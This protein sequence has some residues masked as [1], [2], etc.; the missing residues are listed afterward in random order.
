MLEILGEGVGKVPERVGGAYSRVVCGSFHTLSLLLQ[1]SQWAGVTE[2]AMPASLLAEY[3]L[4]LSNPHSSGFGW[5]TETE[6]VRNEKGNACSLRE[7]V[8]PAVISFPGLL[9]NHLSVLCTVSP[10]MTDS[11]LWVLILPA[12][13]LG[14]AAL[15]AKRCLFGSCSLSLEVLCALQSGSCGKGLLLPNPWRVSEHRLNFPLF[16]M[17][18]N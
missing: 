10:G 5:P 12:L 8:V 9:T 4:H 14:P 13:L 16:E 17:L 15:E 2:G 6:V 3:S 11:L 1:P 7:K 18:W